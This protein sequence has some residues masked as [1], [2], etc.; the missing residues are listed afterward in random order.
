MDILCNYHNFD[1]QWGNHDILWM[2]AAAGNDCCIANVVRGQLRYGNQ[3]VL[4]D[5]YGI[6]M[7]PSP[8]LHLMCMATTNV[9]RL[10]QKLT[11]HQRRSVVPIC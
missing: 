9:C 2:G 4:E 5:G 1:I 7:L 11:L 3:S 6:N 10:C 8:P